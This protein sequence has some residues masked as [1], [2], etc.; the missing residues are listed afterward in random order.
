MAFHSEL[1][2]YDLIVPALLKGDINGLKDA[3][4]LTPGT[5]TFRLLRCQ[6]N[7][8]FPGSN[9]YLCSIFNDAGIPLKPMLAHPT[10]ALTD[11]LDRFENIAFTCEYKYDGERAQI[12]K[13]DDGYMRIYSRNSENMSNKYPDVMER[14]G[15]V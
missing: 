5:Y 3:C 1:P 11:I 6:L 7:V 13:L 8:R 12:H 4:K 14:L 15:K 2:C 9:Y 10:K